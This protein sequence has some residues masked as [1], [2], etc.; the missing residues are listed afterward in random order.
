MADLEVLAKAEGVTVESA[1]GPGGGKLA[2]L[3]DPNGFRVEVVA[4]QTLARPVSP[5]SRAPW[6]SSFSHDRPGEAK[7]IKPGPAHVVRLGHVVLSVNN[8]EESLDWWRLRFGLIMSDEVRAPNG[9]LAAVF[10]RCDRG[11]EPADHHTLNFAA[12]PGKPAGFHHMAFEVE[13]LD[14]LMAGHEHLKSGG[15]VHDWGIGRHVLGSQVF[16]YW[17]DPFG[18]RVE[19]WTDGDVF[20]A[21]TPTNVT[22]IPT[23]LGRQWGPAAP[24]DFV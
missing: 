1:P 2:A 11:S 16:D 7:R 10:I 12:V 8:A 3:R 5:D 22:D 17:K 4:G 13:D 23:M 19:H 6:N 24:A 18:H 15:F 9:A 20:D 14:D 21:D